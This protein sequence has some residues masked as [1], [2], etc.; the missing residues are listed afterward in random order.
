M[1]KLN[2]IL[3]VLIMTNSHAVSAE[4]RHFSSTV[5]EVTVY[6]QGAMIKRTAHVNLQ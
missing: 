1:Q 4:P 3:I 2:A 5:S 6:L